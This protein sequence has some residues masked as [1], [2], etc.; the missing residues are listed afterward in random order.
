MSVYKVF[1][2]I[3]DEGINLALL[4]IVSYLTAPDTDV[5]P[6]FNVIVE[7]LIV[8][9]FIGSEKPMSTTGILTSMP[10]APALG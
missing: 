4:P 9:G 1:A 2:D 10:V 8:D 3:T 7:P 6:A 5:D